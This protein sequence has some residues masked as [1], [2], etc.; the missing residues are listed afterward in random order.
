MSGQSTRM[1]DRRPF[2]RKSPSSEERVVVE[3]YTKHCIVGSAILEQTC[4][5][6]VWIRDIP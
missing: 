2:C 6:E 3:L 1:G 4:S 5:S